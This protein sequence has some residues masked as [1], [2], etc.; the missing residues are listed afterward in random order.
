MLDSLSQRQ[1]ALGG[2]V[3]FAVLLLAVFI[4]P[5]ILVPEVSEADYNL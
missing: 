4:G 3:T 2:L 1:L 5:S